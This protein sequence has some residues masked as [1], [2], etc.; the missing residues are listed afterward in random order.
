MAR[1]AGNELDFAHAPD[2][3]KAALQRARILIDQRRWDLALKQLNDALAAAPENAY[4][5]GFRA[6]CLLALDREDDAERATQE[7]L[8]LAPDWPFAHWITGELWFRR[9]RTKKAMKAAMEGLKLSPDDAV[10]HA[11]VAAIHAADGH[12]KKTEAAARRALAADPHNL[13]AAN[14]RATALRNLG[15]RREANEALG[16][17]LCLHPTEGSAHANQGWGSLH[18][19]RHDEALDRFQEAL[20]LNPELDWAREGVLEVLRARNPVYRALLAWRLWMERHGTLTWG[21]LIALIY[22]PMRALAGAASMA[23]AIVIAL[24]L[25]LFLP[26]IAESLS[27]FALLFNPRARFILSDD[28]TRLAKLT[29]ALFLAGGAMAG[30]GAALGVTRLLAG[31]VLMAAQT[32]PLTGIYRIRPHTKG[33][34]F[35]GGLFALIVCCGVAGAVVPGEAGIALFVYAALG[36]AASVWLTTVAIRRYGA[37]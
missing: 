3:G 30:A 37:T 11:L 35:M 33:R 12:W 13:R 26:W 19:G 5:H 29:V 7:A 28:E 4:A 36:T 24:T 1:D 34:K 27:N 32:L 16:L 22:L 17:A 14:L 21:L 10:L 9:G 20:R 18:Q 2:P 6:W 8:R 31:G 15:R 23:A 25:S